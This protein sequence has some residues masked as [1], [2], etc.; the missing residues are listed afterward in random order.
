[1]TSVPHKPSPVNG[2]PVAVLNIIP[3]RNSGNLRALATVKI[4]PL[5]IYGCRVVQQSGQTPW[6]SMP[7]RQADDGR[8][9]PIVATEDDELRDAVK[10]AVLTAWVDWQVFRV[11]GAQ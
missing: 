11:G 5:T 1:M 10:A 3:T 2:W 9:F 8:W 6:V 7:T 4:G